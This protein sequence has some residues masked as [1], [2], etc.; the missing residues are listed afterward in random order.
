M[1]KDEQKMFLRHFQLDSV[2]VRRARAWLC[3]LNLIGCCCFFNNVSHAHIWKSIT[4][5]PRAA[6]ESLQIWISRWS[7]EAVAMVTSMAMNTLY[8]PTTLV[9]V[10]RMGSVSITLVT[11][12]TV[13]W[14]SMTR[15]TLV[16]S[17][18]MTLVTLVTSGAA[19]EERR[20]YDTKKLK[21]N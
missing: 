9:T 8:L 12:L 7:Q 13:G 11:F 15:V 18:W 21:G 20:F 19:N 10:V 1:L 14:R 4:A 2:S 6:W 16:L 17:P 5:Q 3:Y